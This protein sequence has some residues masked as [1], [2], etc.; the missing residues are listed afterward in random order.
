MVAIT[1]VIIIEL[2]GSENGWFSENG[3]LPVCPIWTVYVTL[4]PRIDA[5]SFQEWPNLIGSSPE[6]ENTPQ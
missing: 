5:V 1:I 3:S 2:N 6:H 4:M